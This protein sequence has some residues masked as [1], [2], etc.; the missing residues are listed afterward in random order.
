LTDSVCPL[1]HGA[2]FTV[3]G[4]RYADACNLFASNPEEVD[5]KLRVLRSHC[6]AEGRDYDAIRKTV[7]YRGPV[8]DGD[9]DEFVADA[10][11]YA[12][13]GVSQL[14]LMPDRDPVEYTERVAE[15]VPRLADL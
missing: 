1:C 7:V 15:L 12:A 3:G 10:Q 6:E 14:D 2:R 9:S 13:L 4:P 11:R 5:G 8:L